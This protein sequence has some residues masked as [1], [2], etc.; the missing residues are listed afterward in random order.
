MKIMNFLWCATAL[1]ALPSNLFYLNQFREVSI[2]SSEE[3]FSTTVKPKNSGE[4]PFRQP[5]ISRTTFL[6]YQ[7]HRVTETP[8]D[9]ALPDIYEKSLQK[10]DTSRAQLRRLTPYRVLIES[11]DDD[12]SSSEEDFVPIY[13]KHRLNR[14]NE[15]VHKS[16]DVNDAIKSME[17]T[18][19]TKVHKDGIILN[20]TG[21]L[22]LWL[23]TRP[24]KVF[25]HTTYPN[26]RRSTNQILEGLQNIISD[27]LAKDEEINLILCNWTKAAS[28]LPFDDENSPNSINN[29][30]EELANF[31]IRLHGAGRITRWSDVHIIGFGLGAHMAGVTG[32]F[33]QKYNGGLKLGRI[34]GLDP[35]NAGFDTVD[36]NIPADST[37]LLD[38]SDADFVDIIHC[39]SS[40]AGSTMIA[41]HA[42]FYPNGGKIQ[43]GCVASRN[44]A[45]SHERCLDLFS[46]SI[47][48][49]YLF[50]ACRC[51]SWDA[52]IIWQ[53]ECR[54]QSKVRVVMGDRCVNTA[55]GLFF[56]GL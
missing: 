16:E 35:A 20:K 21:V 24:V 9:G 15:T 41:G 45:C 43:P 32:W 25:I 23:E 7:E 18:L 14:Q 47:R 22:K 34:T 28:V 53:C 49:S 17:Y 1:F 11:D 36:G 33:I 12:N 19:Y 55:R 54:T 46:N 48:N 39:D 30:G 29:L 5:S 50:K 8:I 56:L 38:R 44:P 42:D 40:N 31:L 51:S 2:S 37:K 3:I 6:P 4:G 10:R 52:F 13:G 26:F 27:Y